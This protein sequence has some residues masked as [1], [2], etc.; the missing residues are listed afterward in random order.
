VDVLWKDCLDEERDIACVLQDFGN[1]AKSGAGHPSSSAVKARVRSA[2]E[3]DMKRSCREFMRPSRLRQ[4]TAVTRL[5]RNPRIVTDPKTL[6]YLNAEVEK[7][8]REEQSDFK[9]NGT[10]TNK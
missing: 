2:G 4:P 5:L 7:R 9:R 6:A 3:N 1:P 8:M 10:H